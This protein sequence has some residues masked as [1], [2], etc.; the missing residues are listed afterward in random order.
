MRL[1]PYDTYILETNLSK[2]RVL[3]ILSANIRTE[4]SEPK[5]NHAFPKTYI[6]QLSEE[7]FAISPYSPFSQRG[8]SL[9]IKGRFIETSRLVSI[10]MRF[11]WNTIDYVI[12]GT[13]L[14]CFAAMSFFCLRHV[15]FRRHFNAIDL[16]P[17][18]AFVF[19]YLIIMTMFNMSVEYRKRELIDLFANQFPE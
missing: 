13:V 9:L 15:F 3:S 16:L 12:N 4:E 1:I 19:A 7:G 6:G 11:L 5:A 18:L 2:G 10:E 8:I 14:G 17:V